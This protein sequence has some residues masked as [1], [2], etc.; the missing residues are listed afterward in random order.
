M[1][2]KHQRPHRRR[3]NHLPLITAVK[4][5]ANVGHEGLFWGIFRTS[6]SEV[7]NDVPNAGAMPQSADRARPLSLSLKD[8]FPPMTQCCRVGVWIKD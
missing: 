3:I 4:V 5:G 2:G 7:L 6:P 8:G 1:H